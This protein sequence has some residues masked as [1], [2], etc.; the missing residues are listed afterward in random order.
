MKTFPNTD[1]NTF[2]IFDGNCALFCGLEY[3]FG[4]HWV[5]MMLKRGGLRE[6]HGIRGDGCTDCL[7]R[8]VF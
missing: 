3:V 8:V 1:R 2:E 6:Q 5:P 7:V 4:M